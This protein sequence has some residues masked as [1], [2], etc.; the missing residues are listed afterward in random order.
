MTRARCSRHYA[1]RPI[2]CRR[3]R[4]VADGRDP[5]LDLY[6]QAIALS[7]LDWIGYLSSTGVY[8]D[9]G[10]AWVDESAPIARAPGGRNA[11]G[12]R[13]AGLA[14]RVRVFR[15]P[16]IY[17]PGR[18]ALDRVREGKAHRVDLARSGVQPRA[19]R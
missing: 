12:R 18:S 2:Y 1:A 11:G 17:G 4:P 7:P 6:G 19:C 15:L 14:Q 9:A 3:F 10:G 8:G 13:V 16:G 5:V